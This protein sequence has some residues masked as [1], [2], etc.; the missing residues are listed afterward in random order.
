MKPAWRV[1][2]YA[3]MPPSSV[4][5]ET[6]GLLFGLPAGLNTAVFTDERD[7]DDFVK[8]T[9]GLFAEWIDPSKDCLIT[10][11]QIWTQ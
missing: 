4:P 8:L 7:A 5:F 10:K 11:E 6:R 2:V 9:K 1:T 3:Q